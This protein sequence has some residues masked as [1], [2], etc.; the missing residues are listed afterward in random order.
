MQTCLGVVENPHYFIAKIKVVRSAQTFVAVKNCCVVPCLCQRN[1]TSTW[2]QKARKEQALK[3]AI[4]KT[5]VRLSNGT[6]HTNSDGNYNKNQKTIKI[7]IVK[8]FSKMQK[9]VA[10]LATHFFC[11]L[12]CLECG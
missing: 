11:D 5:I 3:T 1:T 2:V 7:N 8:G 4:M 12:G 10:H 9:R 6:F